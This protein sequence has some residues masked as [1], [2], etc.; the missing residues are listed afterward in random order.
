MNGTIEHDILGSIINCQWIVA[1]SP[2]PFCYI[3]SQTSR[4]RQKNSLPCVRL[5]FTGEKNAIA[6]PTKKRRTNEISLAPILKCVF[7]SHKG[8]LLMAPG[9]SKGFVND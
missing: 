3:S 1:S 6:L 7:L 4:D 5:L 9:L 8:H 2:F